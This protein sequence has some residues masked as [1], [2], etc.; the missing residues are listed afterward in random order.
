MKNGYEHFIKT[1]VGS[2]EIHPMALF[3][4]DGSYKTI[5]LADRKGTPS[6]IERLDAMIKLDP[7]AF[8][9]VYHATGGVTADNVGKFVLEDIEYFEGSR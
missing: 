3:A 6:N 7:W 2:C 8:I 4:V 5:K 1:I 9:G